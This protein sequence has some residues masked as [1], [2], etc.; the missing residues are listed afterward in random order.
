[1][2][3][4]SRLETR[5]HEVRTRKPGR[6]APF[7]EKVR[8]ALLTTGT[9]H[10]PN[11]DV[12]PVVMSHVSSLRKFGYVIDLVGDSYVCANPEHDPTPEQFAAV[13]DHQTAASNGSPSRR[14]RRSVLADVLPALGADL[15]V[16]MV[17]FGR[18][19]DP[20]LVVADPAGNRFTCAVQQIETGA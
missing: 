1:M 14:P 4:T 12:R 2:A 11:E 20:T 16:V 13:R 18:D 17:G 7:A 19:G 3:K 9:Y 5:W 10:I 6:D 8:H 15:V